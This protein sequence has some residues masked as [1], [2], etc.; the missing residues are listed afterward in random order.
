MVYVVWTMLIIKWVLT[1]LSSVKCINEYHQSMWHVELAPSLS[2]LSTLLNCLLLGLT[3]WQYFDESSWPTLGFE[4]PFMV[5]LSPG[6]RIPDV[7][8]Q[9]PHLFACHEGCPPSGEAHINQ[10]PNLYVPQCQF[11]T[12]QQEVEQSR[13]PAL[14][15]NCIGGHFVMRLLFSGARNSRMEEAVM[16]FYWCKAAGQESLLCSASCWSFPCCLLSSRA[17]A[18]WALGITSAILLSCAS[19][20]YLVTKAPL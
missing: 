4:M 17:G 20:K 19:V 13:C 15:Q 10:Y 5:S 11:V 9:R 16:G 8:I 6:P 3:G 7:Q 18:P 2:L 1:P 14:E 12:L